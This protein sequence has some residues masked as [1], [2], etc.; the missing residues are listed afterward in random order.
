LLDRRGLPKK[1]VTI[2]IFSFII[3]CNFMLCLQLVLASY[4]SDID[5]AHS[6][7][8]NA[9]TNVLAAKKAG[10][11]IADLLNR[12]NDAAVLLAQAENSR[13]T[14]DINEV[15][16][17]AESSRQMADRV[18]EDAIKLLNDQLAQS[19]TTFWLTIVLSTVGVIVF[20]LVL[21]IVWKQFKRRFIAKLLDMKHEVLKDAS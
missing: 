12:L 2:A 15:I 9:F 19:K 1:G 11:N 18:N 10:G 13:G 5:A 6:S 3:I 17:N 4:E 8:N 21:W 16:S 20:I 7:I 14:G